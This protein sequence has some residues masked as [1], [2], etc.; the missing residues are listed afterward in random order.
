M[1]EKRWATIVYLDQPI[2]P[3]PMNA[4]YFDTRKEAL[5]DASK[6]AKCRKIKVYVAQVVAICSSESGVEILQH[7]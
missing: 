2:H 7:E 6:L 4:F 5:D 1:N 3:R